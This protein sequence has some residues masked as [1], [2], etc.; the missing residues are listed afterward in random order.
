MLKNI[1]LLIFWELTNHL[2][3]I[4]KCHA[5]FVNIKERSTFCQLPASKTIFFL[6]WTPFKRSSSVQNS[7]LCRNFFLSSKDLF[8]PYYQRKCKIELRNFFLWF[9]NGWRMIYIY[10]VGDF[11]DPLKQ[12]GSCTWILQKPKQRLQHFN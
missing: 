11:K 6:I 3:R 2:S 5:I 4:L 8:I 7:C 9:F 10:N 1:I 12:A